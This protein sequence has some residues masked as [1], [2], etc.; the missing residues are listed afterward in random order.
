MLGS[1]EDDIP[2]EQIGH[3]QSVASSALQSEDGVF[4]DS[5]LDETTLESRSVP[6]TQ[7]LD[8]TCDEDDDPISR[9]RALT[10][11]GN[12]VHW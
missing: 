12:L 4:T 7:M 9:E 11:L 10:Y 1:S 6:D 8:I 3:P 2:P 5:D